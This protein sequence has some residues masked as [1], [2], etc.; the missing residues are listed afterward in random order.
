MFQ[1]VYLTLTSLLK[2]LHRVVV[3]KRVLDPVDTNVYAEIRKSTLE[4]D[5]SRSKTGVNNGPIASPRARNQLTPVK[6]E[7]V[8][9]D[10]LQDL[11]LIDNYIYKSSAECSKPD[12]NSYQP[13]TSSVYS[14]L[15]TPFTFL[16]HRLASAVNG[17]IIKTGRDCQ[18]EV[19]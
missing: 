5:N 3:K 6:A 9:D 1:P 4:P 10:S 13:G 7:D 2:M 15:L 14:R 8:H 16:V 18:E 11:T 19:I 12:R 17:F